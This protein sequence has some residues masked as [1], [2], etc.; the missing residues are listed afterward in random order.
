MTKKLTKGVTALTACA[1]LVTTCANNTL[2]IYAQPADAGLGENLALNKKG[3]ASSKETGDN[4]FSAEKAFDGNTTDQ[5]NS[6]WSCAVGDGPHWIAVDLGQSQTFQTIRIYWETRKA[7]SYKIQTS[8]NGEEWTDQKVLTT[9]PDSKKQDI[10]FEEPVTAQHVR[11]YIDKF[12]QQDPDSNI[13]WNTISIFEMEVYN[14]VYQD[15]N[16]NVALRKTATASSK[17]TG[18]DQFGA[19][20][21]FDGNTTDK[22]NSRWSSAVGDGPHWLAVDLGMPRT[23]QT[24]RLVWETR[25]ATNY[26]IQ[27]SD[28]GIHWEDQK[29]LTKRPDSKT[30][31]IILDSPVQAR[32]V[33]LH[34]DK[35][36][37][38]DPDSDITWNT[39]SIYEMEVYGGI[40]KEE[41]SL[42]SLL[43]KI[44]VAEP[45]KGD[46]KLQVTLPEAEG[47]EVKYNGT[48]FEQV[49]DD[50]L[51]IYEPVVDKTVKVSFKATNTETEEYKFKELEITIPGKH[52]VAPEDNTAP[53]VLPEIQEWK[54]TSGSFT[55]N[56]S[57]RVIY[58]DASLQDA[59]QALV[60]DYE[61]MTGKTLSA[62]MGDVSQAG[63]G[64]VVLTLAND[65][66]K[67]FMDEG[68]GMQVTDRIVVEAETK[69]GAYFATR[70]ILQSIKSSGNVPCG[71]ARDYPLYKIRGFIL[72]V[73]RKTFTMD[74]LKD[75][76][77][78]MA[79]YKMNDLQVHLNDNYIFLE[80]YTNTGRDPMTAY[81][82]FRLESDI[83]KGGNNGLNQADLTSKDVFYT[84]D[85]FRD[86]IKESRNCGVNIVPEFDTPA[87]S[88]ALT[89]VRPDLRTGTSG[90]QNDHLDLAGQYDESL[91]FVKSIFDEYM[92]GENPV[93][94]QDTMI[95][96]GADEY[97]ANKEAYRRFSDDMLKYVQSTGRTARIWG[98]LSS[99]TGSTPVIAKDVQ[100]N[101]W[102]TGWANMDK[103]YEQGFDLINCDD[104]QYYVVPNA[105]YYYDYL[106]DNVL[107]N[108]PLNRQNTTIPNGDKQMFGGAIA[109]WNDMIDEKDNGVTE[110]DVYDRIR[111]AIPLFG[112]KSW[113]KNQKDL[114]AAKET[115]HKLGDAPQSNFTYSVDSKSD[116]ILNMPMDTL[117]DTSSNEFVVTEGKN[118]AIEKVDGKNALK[119][120]GNESYI[121]TSLETVGLGNSLRMKV[122]RMSDS[123]DE[124]ILLES[125]YGTIK[126]VQK[127][128]GKVGFTREN[129]DYSF[130]YTLPVNEW[131][132]LEIKNVQNRTTLLVNGNV[133]DVI[134]DGEKVAGRPLLATMMIPTSTIGSKTNAFEGYVDDIRVGKDKQFVSTMPLEYELMTAQ[135]ILSKENE[136]VLKPAIEQALK[137]VNKYDPTKEE[138]DGALKDLKSVLKD[139]KY[140]KADYSRV[141]AYVALTKD[142][143]KF[144]SESVENVTRVLERIRQDLPVS[145]QS[146]VD[147]YEK[148]LR[149]ALDQLEPKTETD[150]HYVDNQLITPTASS[151]Q[152]EGSSPAK[153]FD[154]NPGTIWH[155]KWS[156]TKMPHW[157]NM[158]F[159]E[160]QTVDGISYL[161]R[162]TGTNGNL[163]KYEIQVSDNGETFQ[164]IAEGT[165]ANANSSAEKHIQ[166]D[167]VTT[168]HLRIKFIQAPNNNGSAAEIKVKLAQ[169]TP[170]KEGLTSAIDAEKQIKNLGYTT[171]TWNAF[172]ETLKQAEQLLNS[173]NAEVNA[174]EDMKVQLQ[175]KRVA[176]TLDGKTEVNKDALKEA[177]AKKPAKE[178]SAYTPESWDAYQSALK[179]AKVVEANKKATQKQVD[180]ATSALNE[181]LAGL[182]EKPVVVEVNKD[183]LKEA[184]AKKPAKEQSAY[185]P[186][187]WDAY[188]TALNNAQ[189]VM[190]NAKASQKDVDE[191][192]SALNNALAGLKEKEAVDVVNKDALKDAIKEAEVLKPSDYVQDGN[193]N[194]FQ[195]ALKSAK[196]VLAD[197]NASQKD[198]DLALKVL[199]FSKS[200]LK[201]AEDKKSDSN[202]ALGLHAGLFAT[203]LGSSAL[204]A[205]ILE[206]L[207]R[208]K[209]NKE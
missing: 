20:K 171:T 169:V 151:Y 22:A 45:K 183:A 114:A 170:D 63:A 116:E 176:L 181:A 130:N 91:A 159:K 1:M 204:G 205:A 2:T 164:T 157:I 200:N 71:E 47:F 72:D 34:I 187:S 86:F 19:A 202:T 15:P 198:V 186:E 100:M 90:R 54:G 5:K 103:M 177:L 7:T 10:I 64:D 125:P 38:K 107:Y 144:T 152:D 149:K 132:E 184:L 199:N 46:K 21:A 193:W 41:V 68:Y 55:L 182:K 180:K 139:V 62:V 76:V 28:D 131:V 35:F 40:P 48:D 115:A 137:V 105:G 101:L 26:R 81:S 84:K 208:K 174:V 136:T 42:D 197:E 87:H 65:S 25:K 203:L 140:E 112:A 59:A 167:A 70:T 160:P 77:Q 104:G 178:Q 27:T 60:K 33:R 18:D 121:N 97:T 89:K 195:V 135:G 23:I 9:R 56:A 29:V 145:S 52:R 123:A 98:S 148:S 156:I 155:T 133:V 106:N 110:Y 69:Q 189:K 78:E 150:R 127:E 126:A 49:V 117:K 3:T 96:I 196:E 188:Q 142:L 8:D 191:A 185:T 73:G 113:G 31:D 92:T 153:A 79:W 143:S 4:Q 13:K 190:D 154:N 39:I 83:K 147:G 122:K 163:T 168:K 175:V 138:V 201:K 93:F 57:S 80:N 85:E 209:E 118:A 108:N 16:E 172:N 61:Q 134:G 165:V 128:T 192:T 141:D 95:H 88:L 102:N 14:N 75:V 158:E 53:N 207:R 194:K 24:V 43:Q 11:L 173:E 179:E 67:G 94:D 99:L 111:N 120:N 12:D 206:S 37:Q 51:N 66:S 58:T 32:H 109:V 50:Q 6:R 119:L 36:D 129:H 146:V 74:F 17:E 124:Q 44:E 166:F 161:P 30:Q 82:G 162:Q